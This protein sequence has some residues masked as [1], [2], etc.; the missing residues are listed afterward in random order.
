MRVLVIDDEKPLADTL[1]LILNVAGYEVMTAYD[2][3]SALSQI[4]SFLPD[5][6]ISD[7]VMPGMNGIE[8]CGKIQKEHPNCHIILFSGQ[9]ATNELM[10]TARAAGCDWELLAKPVHPEDLLAKLASLRPHPVV[11]P[12]VIRFDPLGH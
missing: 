7:V 1:T 8:T 2:G 4:E 12:R 5:V 3:S 10:K 6:V 9:A 11:E